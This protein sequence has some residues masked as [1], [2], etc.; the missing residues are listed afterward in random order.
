V[1]VASP[2]APHVDPSPADV[3]AGPVVVAPH[4]GAVARTKSRFQ[5]CLIQNVNI[6]VQ[7]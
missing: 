1:G 6:H 4:V 5:V 7:N 3:D 2:N